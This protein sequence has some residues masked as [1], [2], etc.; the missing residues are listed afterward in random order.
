MKWKL[1]ADVDPIFDW[2]KK[3]HVWVQT[4]AV[5][6]SPADDAELVEEVARALCKA[7]DKDPDEMV[8]TLVPNKSGHGQHFGEEPA[9]HR[10]KA[11]AQSIIRLL[12]G[13]GK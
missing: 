1:V 12:S 7:V 6:A 13:E 4:N 5:N 8:S 9:W 3:A 2:D 11:E 10:R